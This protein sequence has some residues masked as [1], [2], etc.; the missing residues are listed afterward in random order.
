MKKHGFVGKIGG[1]R[2][3]LSIPQPYCIR[4]GLVV[5]KNKATQ[6]DMVKA[7]PGSDEDEPKRKIS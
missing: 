4:C 1:K 5:M 6:K 7:C 2:A 3:T